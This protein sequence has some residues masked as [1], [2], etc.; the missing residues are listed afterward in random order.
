MDG[1]WLQAID[2]ESAAGVTA[3]GGRVA[4]DHRQLDDGKTLL[5][6]PSQAAINKRF[7]HTQPPPI[8]VD[9]LAPDTAAVPGLGLVS[10]KQAGHANELV[11]G[12]G[13]ANEAARCRSILPDAL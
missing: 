12:H 11:L 1:H 13:Q 6:G 9:I 8:R 4:G 5:S 7:S 2:A 3:N 10:A